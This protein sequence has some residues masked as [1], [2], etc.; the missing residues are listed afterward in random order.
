[1]KNLWLGLILLG[2]VG[3]RPAHAVEFWFQGGTG[4][5]LPKVSG[6]SDTIGSALGWGGGATLVF[7]FKTRYAFEL[8]GEYFNHQ[9][10]HT[11]AGIKYDVS[12]PFFPLLG[13]FW[14]SLGKFFSL[15]GGGYYSWVAGK[16]L[17]A[18]SGDV[19]AGSSSEYGLKTK[20][21]GGYAGLGLEFPVK[22][23]TLTVGAN[24]FMGVP[25]LALSSASGAVFKLSEV[26]AMI[27]LKFGTKKK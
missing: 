11:S 7:P 14:V 20:D 25:N 18:T 17:T 8:G 15:R 13:G 16:V 19:G 10:T 12:A 23:A 22:K 21:Y 27:G 26:Q 2:V 5:S 4:Y 6:V 3:V 1:M 9:W 24:Y